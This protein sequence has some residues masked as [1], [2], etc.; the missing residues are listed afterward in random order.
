MYIIETD[1][2]FERC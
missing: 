2:R 1:I